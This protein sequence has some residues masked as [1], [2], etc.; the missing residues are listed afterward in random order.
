MWQANVAG[1]GPSQIIYHGRAA[2]FK[3]IRA[4]FSVVCAEQRSVQEG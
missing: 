3:E 4:K 1:G 2:D